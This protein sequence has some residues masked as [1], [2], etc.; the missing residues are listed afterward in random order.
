MKINARETHRPCVPND[1]DK[2]NAARPALQGVHPVSHPRVLDRVAVAAEPDI[3]TV[4]AVKQ[5]GNPDAKQFQ[6][7]HQRQVGQKTDLPCVGLWP[8]DRSRTGDQ[9]VLEQEGPTSH[10]PEK[11]G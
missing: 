2:S 11:K 10:I 3:E 5:N 1:V 7:E 4:K 8:T 9:D 6:K